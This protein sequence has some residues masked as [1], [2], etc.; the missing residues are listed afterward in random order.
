MAGEEAGDLDRGADPVGGLAPAVALVG[1]Q[2][3][4]DGDVA[5]LEVGDDL[6]GFIRK[7]M[8]SVLLEE[9]RLSADRLAALLAA[10]G[11]SLPLNDG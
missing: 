9:P 8:Y 6:F 10:R 4:V 1:E 3:V 2:D 5:L 11:K 7:E